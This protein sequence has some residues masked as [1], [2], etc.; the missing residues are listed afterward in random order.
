M[1]LQNVELKPRRIPGFPGFFQFFNK[2]ILY[3]VYM[4][5]CRS[6]CN[7]GS[8]CSMA[9]RIGG[10]WGS[11]D[12]RHSAPSYC[13]APA[14]MEGK[15]HSP[16]NDRWMTSKSG[17]KCLTQFSMSKSQSNLLLVHLQSLH[18]FDVTLLHQSHVAL[19]EETPLPKAMIQAS[20]K[21]HLHAGV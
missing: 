18:R 2:C 9:S 16:E 7:G 4:S 11:V 19:L 6:T 5:V 21:G 8:S 10:L 3:T 20:Q 14:V 13:R 1:K 12:T 17:F 15:Q